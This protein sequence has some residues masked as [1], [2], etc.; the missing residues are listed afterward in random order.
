M[1]IV[2][3]EDVIAGI[4]LTSVVDINRSNI[5]TNFLIIFFNSLKGNID[6][7]K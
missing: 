7:V 6:A 5:H 4:P 3:L 1:S 2:N